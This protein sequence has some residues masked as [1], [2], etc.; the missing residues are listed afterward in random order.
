VLSLHPGRLERVEAQG[1]VATGGFE[2]VA[3]ARLVFASGLVADLTASR[4][5]PTARRTVSIWSSDALVHCDLTAKTVEIVS[6]SDGVRT[7]EFS[8]TAV[9][10]AERVAMKDRFF[11]DILPFETV[12]VAD[13]NAIACEQDDFLAAIREGRPPLVTGAAGAAAVEIAARVIDAL[14]CTR[15]GRAG[16]A[17]RTPTIPMFPHRKTG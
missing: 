9:P 17:G 10:V 11:T 16:S 14:E 2:D 6:P 12:T 13:A 8:A 7:G 15:F 1:I 4:I 3:R 5:S